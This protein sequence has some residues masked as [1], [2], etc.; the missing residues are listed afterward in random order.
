[1]I[2][3]NRPLK[4]ACWLL[5]C[6]LCPYAPPKPL[7]YVGAAAGLP[8]AAFEQGEVGRVHHVGV[9]EVGSR[10]VADLPV[11][12]AEG[13]LQCSEVDRVHHI[14]V[15]RARAVGVACPQRAGLDVSY[16]PAV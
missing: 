13:A 7:L 4:A 2:I 11:A 1:M 3:A 15:S 12:L 6:A 10:I 16:Q 5:S 14:E 9:V 8:K